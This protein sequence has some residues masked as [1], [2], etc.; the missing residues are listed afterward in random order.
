VSNAHMCTI[1]AI[2]MNQT[3]FELEKVFAEIRFRSA[4]RW[5]VGNKVTYFAFRDNGCVL[6]YYPVMIKF[7]FKVITLKISFIR[8][9]FTLIFSEDLKNL[10]CYQLP[11]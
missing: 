3:T 2:G 6:L 10:S 11:L 1:I 9:V 8:F 7:V 4:S 5:K